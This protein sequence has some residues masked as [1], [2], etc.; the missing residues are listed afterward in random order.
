[1]EIKRMDRHSSTGL[2]G[3]PKKGGAGGKGTWG[4]GGLDDLNAV[5][6]KDK[7]DPNYDSEEETNDD[8]VL[9][10]TDV[11]TDPIQLL[12][13]EF[14]A[15]GDLQ[16]TTRDLKEL[17]VE[18]DHDHFI[19]KL[20]VRSMEKGAYERE[21]VSKL[22]VA[23]VGKVVSSEKMEQAFQCTLDSL[24]DIVIDAPNGADCLSKFIARAI[25]DEVI[26]PSFLR[27]AE[28]NSEDIVENTIAIAKALLNQPFRSKRLHHI[29]GAGDNSSVKRL[30][31]ETKL[32]IEEYLTNNDITEADQ[33]LREL[34]SRGFHPQFVKI[35]LKIALIKEDGDQHRIMSL[36]SSFAKSDLVSA[37]H[38]EMGFGYCCEALEDIK[39]DIPT[40][41]KT[42]SR[43]IQQ[44]KE[45]GWLNK[46]FEPESKIQ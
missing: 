46:S 42:L 18:V 35:A 19:K 39:L 26:P 6:V 21:L 32:I 22:M 2:V 40:A 36:L 33:S 38:I 12:I 7:H 10:K 17:N 23:L 9:E 5:G 1:M 45:E 44:A 16:E 29:W 11:I 14:F 30:E 4:K 43:C 34:N 27:H 13:D 24:E 28:S 37:D 20:M 8:V 25:F 31:N 15:S 41:P 3:S